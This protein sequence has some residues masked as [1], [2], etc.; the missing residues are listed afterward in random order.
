MKRAAIYARVSTEDQSDSG[1]SLPGQIA[2]C[3]AYAGRL[4][5][6]IVAEFQE[7]VSGAKAV[8]D[9]TQG[10][11][12]FEMVRRHEVDAIIVH[13]VDRLS[14]DIVDLLITVRSWL[15]S[16]VEIHAGDVGKIE[17]DNDITLII[18]GWQGTDERKKIRER[19]MLESG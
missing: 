6:S 11:R 9:R 12:L 10:A 14:R 18:K 16:G 2:E 17:S 13:R 4:D 8:T 1:Y 15:K 3:R 19:S 7:D 5:A